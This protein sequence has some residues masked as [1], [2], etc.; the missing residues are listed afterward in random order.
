[1]KL[2]MNEKLVKIALKVFVCRIGVVVY[3]IL[4]NISTWVIFSVILFLFYKIIQSP[5]FYVTLI[6]PFNKSAM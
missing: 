2:L 5:A 1:M 3:S 4:Y 6:L